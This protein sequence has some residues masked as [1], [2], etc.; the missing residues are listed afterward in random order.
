VLLVVMQDIGR[1]NNVEASANCM[2]DRDLDFAW[3]PTAAKSEHKSPA[4]LGRQY[5][6]QSAT[7]L[8][9]YTE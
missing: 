3:V 6:H 4:N 9:A 5:V 2:V 7:I 8:V 1:E